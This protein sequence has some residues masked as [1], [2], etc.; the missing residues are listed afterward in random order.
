MNAGVP[1]ISVVIASHNAA[2][3]IGHCLRALMGQTM[4]S[5]LEIIVAD[6][7]TD[8]TDR[9]VREQFP[10]VR[11]LHF[12]SPL[13]IPQLRGHAIAASRGAV[14]AI[15]DPY[16][17][18]A[19]DWAAAILRA[20]S[21]GEHAVIGGSVEMSRMAVATLRAWTL[22]FNE[23]GLFMPPINAGAADLV[24]GSNVSYA[25]RVLF[26]GERP[27]YPVFWKTFVN[28][29]SAAR[30]QPM[31]LDPAIQVELLKP[32]PFA[33][34]LRSRVDHGRCFAAMRA[35]RA[36]AG[37]RL[38]RAITAP[39]VPLVLLTRWSRGIWTKGRRRGRYVATLPLQC[40]LFAMWGAGEFM[41]Y[42]F[43]AGRSA[44]RLHY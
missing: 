2:S 1:S 43:G 20:H 12:D 30:L 31:W 16:S 33:E 21:S 39:L 25:R 8:G 13:T 19:D 15:I 4:L 5:Q 11:L 40:A 3:V 22:Y 42:A 36:S 35:E 23:Y 6:S 41:G 17:V 34:F 14:I 29:E 37:E 7:S 9:I 32:I 27:R 10:Q 28:W 44:D 18:T 26:D 24:P 38:L